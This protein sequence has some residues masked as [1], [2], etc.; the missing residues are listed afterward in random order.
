M[1][2]AAA[3]QESASNADAINAAALRIRQALAQPLSST[4]IASSLARVLSEFNRD[5]IRRR[6][7]VEQL[8]RH[9]GFSLPLLD[10]SLDA[11][12][13]PFSP[14]PLESLAQRARP[15]RELCA[16]VLAGN[17]AGAG[18][19]EIVLALIAGRG[20]LIKTASSEPVFWTE[21]E[22]ALVE[23][24]PQLS[25]RVAVF[26][27]S[28]ENHEMSA[29]LVDLADAVVV[30]GDDAT[31]A[32][33]GNRRALIGFGSK[34]SGAIVAI[35]GMSE[36]RLGEIAAAI[37]LDV[38]LYEQ[39]GC[40]SPHH[41]FVIESDRPRARNFAH[42]IAEQ[43]RTVAVR[44]P[45]PSHLP[46]HDAA[47]IRRVREVARWRSIGADDLELFEGPRLDWTVV[48]DAGASFSVSPGYRTLFVSAAADPI[49]LLRR[50]EPALPFLEAISVAAE[51]ASEAEIRATLGHLRIPRICAPGEMQSPPLDWRHGGGAFFD[52]MFN[53]R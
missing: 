26:N 16:F 48:F 49:D 6:R 35:H 52:R 23:I 8:S 50:L 18:I 13:R 4:R 30:Y 14:A 40:L 36:S 32:T 19:H 25:Q 11:L 22:K 20:L 12:L 3:P 46:L 17:A 38:S 10:A 27:W 15:R 37:A 31:V 44:L 33:L 2:I 9:T 47:A 51:A 7:V 5:H 21:F 28:R 24:D 39:L 1:S 34:I 41:V 43:L 29:G 42:R 53:P 45:A